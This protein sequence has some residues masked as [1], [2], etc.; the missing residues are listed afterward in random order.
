ML[1]NFFFVVVFFHALTLANSTVTV[2]VTYNSL[3]PNNAIQ[4]ATSDM[5]QYQDK[6]PP[7]SAVLVYKIVS[8]DAEHQPL[9]A[10]NVYA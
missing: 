8:L 2:T 1:K 5:L 6:T 9:G 10:L 4:E 3:P 7:N